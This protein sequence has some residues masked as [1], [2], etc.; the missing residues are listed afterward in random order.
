[1]LKALK[2]ILSHVLIILGTIVFFVCFLQLW[3]AEWSLSA[4][5]SVFSGQN[6]LGFDPSFDFVADY[7]TV[8]VIVLIGIALEQG[9]DHYSS[10]GLALFCWAF[11]LL[12]AP[13]IGIFFIVMWIVG[14]IKRIFGN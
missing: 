6:I 11:Q 1:M 14:L 7:I 3:E 8:S 4:Y 12:V 13:F 10:V 5:H 2:S 9:F